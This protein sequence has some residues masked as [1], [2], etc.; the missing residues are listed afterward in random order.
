MSVAYVTSY[1]STI[2]TLD[3]SPTDFEIF[4]CKA[5]K[6]LD[7]PTPPLFDAP[8]QGKHYSMKIK[9]IGLPYCENF[10][11]LTSTIFD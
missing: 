8:A 2:V 3:V 1:W 7:F 6:W 9:A 10:M 4:T 11:I 5:R